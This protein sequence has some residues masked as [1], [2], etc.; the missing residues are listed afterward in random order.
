[1]AAGLDELVVEPVERHHAGL[2]GA[3]V[4]PPCHPLVGVLLGDLG[5]EL[6]LHAGDLRD[7][8]GAC[9]GH[10][11]DALDTLHELR[12]RLELRPPVKC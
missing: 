6:A 1:L 7:P 3:L 2:M 4:G 11:L 10:L 8:V 12:E 5:V 9:R